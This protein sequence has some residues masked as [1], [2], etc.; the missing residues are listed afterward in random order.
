MRKFIIERDIPA[1]AQFGEAQIKATAWKSNAA[2]REL[3]ADIQWAQSYV[4]GTRTYCVMYAKTEALIHRHAALVGLQ[5]A[6]VTE[7]KEMM[8]PSTAYV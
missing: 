6:R 4:A 3:G 5:T 2:I 7:I 8:D 1:G